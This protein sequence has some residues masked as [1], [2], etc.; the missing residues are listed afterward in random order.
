MGRVFQTHCLSLFL[1]RLS[2]LNIITT[3]ASEWTSRVN[4]KQILSRLHPRAEHLLDG[5]SWCFQCAG[6]RQS[7]SV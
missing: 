1:A 3:Q 4:V 6:I 7:D 2:E 5:R